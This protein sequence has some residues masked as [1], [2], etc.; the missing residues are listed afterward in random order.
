[1]LGII[2]G[3]HGAHNCGYCGYCEQCIRTNLDFPA[4][5]V[6]LPNMPVLSLKEIAANHGGILLLR[7]YI[8]LPDYAHAHNCTDPWVHVM[9]R[10][11]KRYQARLAWLR[12]LER[13]WNKAVKI[14]TH[15]KFRHASTQK[16]L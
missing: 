15:W 9:E 2:I 11:I 12:L 3:R 4:S 14:T 7:E 6:Q 8:T 13:V 16:E 1:M 10:K 5:G